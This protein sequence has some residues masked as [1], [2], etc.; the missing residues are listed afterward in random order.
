M[1]A[2]LVRTALDA[3]H[4]LRRNLARALIAGPSELLTQQRALLLASLRRGVRELAAAVPDAPAAPRDQEADGPR[5]GDGGAGG[6]TAG[7][8]MATV[9]GTAGRSTQKKRPRGLP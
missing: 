6:P 2:A 3:L 4:A 5:N 9:D 8:T 1:D 7:A